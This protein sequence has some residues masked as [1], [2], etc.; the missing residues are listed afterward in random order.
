MLRLPVL[1]E[2]GVITPGTFV[3]YLDGSTRPRTGLV[4]STAIEVA[5]PTIW[6]SIGVQIYA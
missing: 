1:E 6:Q 2:T 5:L 3:R 4:R